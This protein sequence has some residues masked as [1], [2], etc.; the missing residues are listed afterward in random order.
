MQEAEKTFS[1]CSNQ[2]PYSMVLRDIEKELVPYS[3]KN[4]KAI[5]VYSP[6]QRGLLT[7]KIKPGH[8]FNEGDTRHGNRFY[9]T[10]NI[11]RV[12]SVLDSLRP[13]AAEK[14]ATLAQLVLRWTIDQPGIT[15]ALAGAR[16]AEQAVQNAKAADVK[17]TKEDITFINDKLGKLELVMP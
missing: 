12:N 17:L 5:I 9:T 14:N 7:G 16:N 1:L 10:E 3:I 6:L 4:N 13:L 8:T 11:T 15:I 2:V